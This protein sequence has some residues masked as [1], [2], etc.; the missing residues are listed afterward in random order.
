M[1]RNR[2]EATKERNQKD[3]TRLIPLW[4]SFYLHSH[5]HSHSYSVNLI[6]ENDQFLVVDKPANLLIHPTKPGGPNTL[7]DELRKFLAFEIIN[8]GQVSIV[9]RLD[10]E[11][12]G[13]VLVAKSNEMARALGRLLQRHQIRKLYQTI[14]W[15]WPDKDQFS[16]DQPL[17]RQ[18]SVMPSK[19]W[20]K[21]TVHHSGYPALTSFRILQRF[22]RNGTRFALIE[23]E[24]KSGRTHQI[25]VHLSHIG[26]PIVGDKIYGPDE[27]CYLEFIA[28]DWTPELESKLLLRRQA[29]HASGLEFVLE[30]GPFNFSA[31]LPQDMQE[32]LPQA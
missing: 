7:W 12:S 25:R 15:G 1:L 13:L 14:V 16:I 29:L 28:S 9:N 21:Q 18:G 11:T 8:G 32:F 6:Y 17:L 22:T 5:S 26:H 24:P 20:L 31:P 2:S 30:N 23:A 10:R 4:P 19:I 3:G 27:N